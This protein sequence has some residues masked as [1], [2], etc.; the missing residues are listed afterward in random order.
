MRTRTRL[1]AA[2]VF[3]ALLAGAVA[4][5]AP[6]SASASAP[7]DLNCTEWFGKTFFSLLRPGFRKPTSTDRKVLGIDGASTANRARAILAN[8]SPGATNQQWWQRNCYRAGGD[9]YTQFMNDKSKLCLDKSEDVPNGNGNAIYQYTCA[10]RTAGS[11]NQ[12]WER[13]QQGGNV[14]NWMLLWNLAGQRCMD[15]HNEQYAN[16]ALLVQW[17][18]VPNAWDTTSHTQ[19]WNTFP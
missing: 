9:V 2:A 6:A 19:Q 15:V 12:M 7:G 18:C 5:P 1:L 17:D 8:Y 14:D 4:L 3:A 10:T 11:D 13:R 16:G